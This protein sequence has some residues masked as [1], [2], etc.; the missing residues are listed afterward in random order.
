MEEKTR[1]LEN[2]KR[3]V[4][5]LQHEG[6]DSRKQCE[7]LQ[8][9]PLPPPSTRSLIPPGCQGDVSELLEKLAA[10]QKLLES[11]QNVISWLN[12]EI[13]ESQVGWKRPSVDS[14]ARAPPFSAVSPY[15]RGGVASRS[16][17]MP[18]CPPGIRGRG[19]VALKAVALVPFLGEDG[20]ALVAMLDAAPH[21]PPSPQH[22]CLHPTLLSGL[23][24]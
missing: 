23:K 2:A 24:V 21:T 18:R 9:R 20:R 17:T 13:T 3:Q 11:N 4:L 22:T 14:L 19:V 10:D 16:P 6:G 7:R 15:T 1:D 8:V 5:T 12:K